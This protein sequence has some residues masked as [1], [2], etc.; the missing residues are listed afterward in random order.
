MED[1]CSKHHDDF[2]GE[3][4]GSWGLLVL[5]WWEI[6]IIKRLV[7]WKRTIIITRACFC[8]T[9]LRKTA[10]GIIPHWH[11]HICMRRGHVICLDSQE[12]ATRGCSA[13]FP[14]KRTFQAIFYPKNRMSALSLTV[15]WAMFLPLTLVKY[16]EIPWNKTLSFA[17]SN[18]QNLWVW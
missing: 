13:F 5:P 18:T 15:T 1:K 10:R 4:S 2:E 11:G 17:S 6:F 8:H 7:V 3:G 12:P 9:R 16:F 14:W